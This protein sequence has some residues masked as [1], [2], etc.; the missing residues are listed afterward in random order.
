MS[1]IYIGT[2][3]Y[4][5]KDWEK[6]FYPVGFK[7]TGYLNFYS[8]YF[9]TVEIN[10]TF[11]SIPNPFLFLSME[12]KT[13]DKFL[14]SVKAHKSITH[15][16]I[17][18]KQVHESILKSIE[19]LIK[20]KKMGVIL[21]QFPYSFYCNTDNIDYITSLKENFKEVDIVIEFRNSSWLN[22]KVLKI[23]RELN[24]GFC[25]VDEPKLPHLMPRTAL[26][27][28]NIFYLRFHGRNS[29]KWW[30]YS[31]QFERYDY[32]YSQDE[33]KEW[34]PKIIEISKETEKT[35][36]YFNNHYKAK[37]VKSAEILKKMLLN[38]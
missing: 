3:G 21:F 26:A 24:I 16:R 10:S 11:Y 29:S 8:E 27:T 25:N 17:S 32:M 23:L 1:K 9:D 5:Y 35:L 20:A 12:K 28:S 7:P 38:S 4:S 33:L 13:P 36:I 19:P 22:N 6:E 30:N 34:V 18:D 14:F 15:E 37:A 31:Q 2:S